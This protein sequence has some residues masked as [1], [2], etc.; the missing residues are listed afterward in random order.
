MSKIFDASL[1]GL[2]EGL[3]EFL[4][5]SSTGHLILF[6]EAISFDKDPTFKI[7][8][9]FGAILAVVALYWRRFLALLVGSSALGF[10]GYRGLALLISAC[11]PG[12]I[13]GVL[14]HKTI[15][16]IL[17]SPMPVAVALITGGILMLILEKRVAPR[18]HDI[19]GISFKHAFIVGIVQCFALWPGMSRSGSSI[20]GGL[21][22]G[23]SKRVSAEFSFILAVPMMTAASVYQLY[24]DWSN[25][26]AEDLPVYLA[27]L[28][29]SFLTALLAIKFFLS[30][31]SKYS[32]AP[33]AWYRIA[34]GGLVLVWML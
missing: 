25:L 17:F 18:I 33:F 32:F 2:V 14:F 12:M 7:I 24:K 16:E 27:G 23:L 20:I 6:G 3:T 34:L 28:L 30:V 15:T 5:V 11:L 22:S 1:M 4:P 21:L 13:F 31:L 10:S 19:D 9:Q 29:V 26:G 8:I